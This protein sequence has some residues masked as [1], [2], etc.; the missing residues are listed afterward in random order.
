MILQALNRYYEVLVS[1]PESGIAPLGYSAAPVSFALNLSAEGKLVGIFPLFE[2][3]QRGKK[4]ME[5]PR[6]M[7]VPEQVVR[8]GTKPSS[9]FLCDN[10]AY[11][12]GLPNATEKD[13]KYGINRFEAFRKFNI[14]LLAKADC[15]EAH[16][17]IAFLES[18]D[19]S[20]GAEDSIIA[21]LLAG[22][23]QGGNLVFKSD[24]SPG[25]AHENEEIRKVWT[26]YKTSTGDEYSSQCLVTGETAPIA[27]IHAKV[28][29]VKDAQSS[30]ASLISFNERAYES[31]N[32][33]KEQGVNSPVSERAAFAYTTALNYLL[34]SQNVN[35]KFTM[36]DTTVVYWAESRDP[37]YGE[38]FLGLFGMEP[39]AEKAEEETGSRDK[40]AER[41]LRNIA[42]KVRRAEGLDTAG[43]LEGLNPET[44]FYVLGLAPNAARIAVRFFHSDPFEK[45]IKK[46]MTHYDDLRIVREYPD[47]PEMIPLW[48]L[49]QE[50]ISKKSSDKKGSPLLAGAVMRAIL[51]NAPYPAAMY[52]ALINRIRADMDDSNLRI[53][54][55]NYPRAAMI[56]AYLLR[57]YRHQ[58]PNPIQE[59]LCMSLNEQ[60][61]IPAYVLGRLFAVLEKVQQEAIGEMNA[62]I[63][64]RYFTSAC[65]TPA[66]VFPV[67]LRLSQHH[68]SKAEYGYA[69]DRRIQDILNLLDVE[70]N[71]IP[72]HLTL[73]EQGVF[74][75]GYYHQRAAFF[76]PKANNTK[77][78]EK[79]LETI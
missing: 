51:L 19:P 78:E 76:T 44:R 21:N 6:R 45:T 61:A 15:A 71:P 37:S 30:G 22:I 53:S 25:F 55:I 56:K 36:G 32:R 68:I 50:M 58:K 38:V 57:K 73:D 23:L 13:P 66:S 33:T 8:A 47:Q 1:D 9:N 77:L 27:R 28:K 52:Y 3:V 18:Y 60:S 70:K 16:S 64:D 49:M 41:L 20:Y 43:I 34:S 17:V 63:K 46:I 2:K 35:R 65:A 26:D 74:V 4:M 79:T 11:V 29:G 67:L 69:S 72:A 42:D 75:L 7:L 39:E 10:S 48:Q 59:V 5:V 24:W 31:Y 12:L 14:G 40:K 54:K 62:T